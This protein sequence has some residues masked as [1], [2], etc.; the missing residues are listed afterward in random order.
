MRIVCLK[1][2]LTEIAAE[3]GFKGEL[4]AVSKDCDYPDWVGSLARV[5]KGPRENFPPAQDILA[6][7][8]SDYVD[9]A[10]LRAL[11]P[12]AVLTTTTDHSAEVAPAGQP[13]SIVSLE[14]ELSRM[15]GKAVRVRSY[16][17]RRLEEILTVFEE[18]GAFLGVGATGRDLA[19]RFKAR[20]MDW[21]DNFYDRMRNKRVAV[22]SAVQPFYLAGY[23]VPDMIT[24]CSCVSA[25]PEAGKP[26]KPISWDEI[27]AFH[28]DVMMIAPEG[29]DLKESLKTFKVMEKLPGWEEVSAVKRGE[30]FFGD[31]KPS[32]Y[33][34]GPRLVDAMG[35]LIS[36]I[37]GLESGYITKRDSFY[38]LRWLELQRHRL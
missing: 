31:G 22:L 37:A 33:R 14:L 19:Q 9:L 30:V 11:A 36:A 12:D 8:C 10:C 17:P 15:F 2:F 4:L 20:I 28:P 5:T 27:V 38:R 1:P 13:P 26:P 16:N 35:V 21:I 7:L 3:L 25:G 18:V 6:E 32:F 24:M 29:K 34:P 23:W